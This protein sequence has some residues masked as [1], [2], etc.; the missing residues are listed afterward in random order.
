MVGER[1]TLLILRELGSGPKRYQDLLESLPSMGTNL[2]AAR[3]KQM[4]EDGLVEKVAPVPP[5]KMQVYATAKKGAKLYPVLK[6]LS[7]FGFE[8]LNEKKPE[9]LFKPHWAI[10]F[11]TTVYDF[12]AAKKA[13]QVFEFIFEDQTLY[14]KVK[15]GYVTV[16]TALANKP[17]LSLEFT[18]DTLVKI[19]SKKMTFQE[20]L[21]KGKIQTVGKQAS[22]KVFLNIFG[23]AQNLK[24]KTWVTI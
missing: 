10:T 12:E 15:N 24:S 9:E 3:L 4:V 17:D 18:Q 1:W 16:E 7:R 23:T 13:N 6:E 22:L 20:A 11:L 14:L 21:Q 19:I 2:L 5:A 8:L